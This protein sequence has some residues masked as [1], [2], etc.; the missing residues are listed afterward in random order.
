MGDNQ[1]YRQQA[2]SCYLTRMEFTT[3]KETDDHNNQSEIN[4]NFTWRTDFSEWMIPHAVQ[5]YPQL[6][7]RSNESTTNISFGVSRMQFR[8]LDELRRVMELELRGILDDYDLRRNVAD[9]VLVMTLARVDNDI[10]ADGG[11][12]NFYFDALVDN[13]HI[14]FGEINDEQFNCMVP[15]ADSSIMSS[16]KKVAVDCDQKTSCSICLEDLSPGGDNDFEEALSMPCLHVYH[17]YCIKKWLSTSH[18]CPLCRFEMPT[19]N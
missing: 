9:H 6:V 1:D 17:D 16:L 18:Y 10:F 3:P 14:V 4:L 11:V 13:Q 7:R 19:T 2:F 15:A 12:F 5:E 8:C